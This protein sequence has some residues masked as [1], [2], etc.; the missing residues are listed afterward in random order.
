M[1]VKSLLSRPIAR[2]TAARESKKS[3]DAH[4]RQ[5]RLLQHL[6]E[7]AQFT[8]FG[9]DHGLKKGM[10]LQ[11]Y[12]SAVPVRD[13]EGLKPWMDRAV[14]GESDVLWPGLPDYFCKTSGTTSGAKFIPITPD[15]MSNHIGS[16]QNALLQYIHNSKNT[17]FVDGKMIFLQGSPILSKTEGGILM[18]RLSGIVAH[19]VPD[20]LQ[21]NRL[22]SLEANCTEPWE[23]KVNA[24]VEETKDQDLRLISGIPSWVQNYFERLLE[25]TGANT[26]K[27]VFPNFE[28]FVFGGVAFEPYR[29][30]FRELIGGDVDTVELFPASEGFFAYQDE[31]EGPGLRL[32]V[33]D[34]IFYEFIPASEYFETDRRRLGLH[35]IELGVQYALIITSNAGLWSYDIGDTVKFISQDPYRLIVTG[36]IKHFTS[37]FGE[38][39]I[40]EE[41]EGAVQDA[42]ALAGGVVAEFHVA[43]EVNPV[44]GL[45]YHEWF[46][47]FSESPADASAFAGAVNDGVILRNPYYRDLIAGSILQNARL[48]PLEKGAFHQAM[49]NRGKLGG[50][51]KP[52]RLANSREFAEE[53]ERADET[54]KQESN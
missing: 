5:Q 32:N 33:D 29:E 31:L 36:R 10:S 49:S 43:P 39:V 22:P 19:H 28:V 26:V 14:K 47:E 13:Y 25:V 1:S 3:R 24:I 34:G 9:R 52:P 38:H 37:A 30:R 54:L 35:E 17:R 53:L 15:S 4:V 11:Q 46:V 8:A 7:R 40:A 2:I 12:Q 42:M 16:A 51:N 21:A 23:A 27:E 6:L 18:G 20:Y 41:V 44:D 45:P 48:R 50:Q